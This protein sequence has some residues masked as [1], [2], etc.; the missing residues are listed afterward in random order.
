MITL[1]TGDTVATTHAQ[2]NPL[3]IDGVHMAPQ[4]KAP[5][6]GASEW[7]LLGTSALVDGG[8]AQH[9]YWFWRALRPEE[10]GHG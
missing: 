9:F 7:V 1:R 4:I 3:P 2:L 5:S 8:G 10:V 6:K